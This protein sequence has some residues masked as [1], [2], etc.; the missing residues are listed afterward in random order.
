M[1]VC[2]GSVGDRF[3]LLREANYAHVDS[4]AVFPAGH[5]GTIVATDIRIMT[6]SYVYYR[7][8]YDGYAR[9]LVIGND[10]VSILNEFTNNSIR[11]LRRQA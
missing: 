8:K 5:E 6:D 10:D 4:Y 9:P 2:K 1:S 11:V 7:V 3:R